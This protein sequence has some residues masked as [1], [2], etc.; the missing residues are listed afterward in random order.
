MEPVTLVGDGV[1]LTTLRD[2]D[3]DL[4]VEY[5]GDPV[6]E[7]FLTTPWPYERSHA[8]FFV[9]EY[10]AGGWA[11]GAE[12]TWAIRE[13]EDGPL[14]GAVGVR[15]PSGSIGYWL[16][17][18]HRGRGFMKAAAE[19]A[20]DWALSAEGAG[21]TELVWEAAVGNTASAELARAIGFRYTGTG[22]GETTGRDG[23]PVHSWHA[24]LTAAD[25]GIRP[26]WEVLA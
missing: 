20:V 25:R 1:V 15:I 3:I 26:H 14:L 5:C 19:L 12:A 16:G 18:P 13:T 24:R 17:A 21:L 4:I 2:T 7:R 11:T 6:F 23:E 22:P 9:R 10:A 8:E